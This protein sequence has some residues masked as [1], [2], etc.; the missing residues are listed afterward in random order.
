MWILPTTFSNDTNCIL[1][2]EMVHLPRPYCALK[3][4]RDFKKGTAFEFC[5]LSQCP[6]IAWFVRVNHMLFE[7]ICEGKGETS[8]QFN[9]ILISIMVFSGT[10]ILFRAESII[11]SRTEPKRTAWKMSLYSDYT[12]RI[13]FLNINGGRYVFELLFSPIQDVGNLY[14]ILSF[15]LDILVWHV[16]NVRVNLG[17]YFKLVFVLFQIDH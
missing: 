11:H 3:R 8:F 1:F 16:M 6:S 15:L 12:R 13:F 10:F 17:R 5:D 4:I 9:Y 14:G 7:H 2:H